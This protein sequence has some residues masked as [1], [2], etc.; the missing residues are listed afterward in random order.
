MSNY[1]LYEKVKGDRKLLTLINATV[2][3]EMRNP[4]NAI[5]SQNLLQKQIN[6]RFKEILNTKQASIEQLKSIIDDNEESIEVLGSSTKI[7]GFLVNDLLDF[8]QLKAKKFRKDCSLFN[9]KTAIQEIYNVCKF[10]AMQIGV[11]VQLFYDNFEG[12]FNIFTD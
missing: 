8:A 7:L 10:K 6:Y 9:L 12:N 1:I 2:S 11:N 4:I 3:H 5:I